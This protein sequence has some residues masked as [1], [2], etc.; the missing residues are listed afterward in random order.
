MI[1]SIK[2]IRSR[3]RCSWPELEQAE[4]QKIADLTLAGACGLNQLNL[5]PD[6]IFRQIKLRPLATDLDVYRW[7][8]EFNDGSILDLSVPR[9]LEGTESKP[10]TISGKR[11]KRVVVKF[12]PRRVARRGQL[13]I[14]AQP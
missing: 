4:W 11:L 14:W 6:R 10:V 2:H 3:F 9:L 1:W 13:E 5:A 8:M 12:D 7:T